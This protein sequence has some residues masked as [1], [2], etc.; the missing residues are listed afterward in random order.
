MFNNRLKVSWTIKAFSF[1]TSKKEAIMTRYFYLT[2]DLSRELV[3]SEVGSELF[4]DACGVL[5]VRPSILNSY[6]LLPIFVWNFTF[7]EWVTYVG[8]V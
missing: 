6:V 3:P 1:A 8:S 5:K 2:Q 4:P 7:N